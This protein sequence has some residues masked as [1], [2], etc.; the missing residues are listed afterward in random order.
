MKGVIAG[1]FDVM[2]PGYVD[3]FKEMSQH[4]YTL[5]VLLHEDPSFERPT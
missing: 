4:C 1:N 5:I 3:R 2:H